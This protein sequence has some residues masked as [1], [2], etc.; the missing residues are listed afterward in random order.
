[1]SIGNAVKIDRAWKLAL[2]RA[3]T[4]VAKEFFEEEHP[5][6]RI[7]HA[8]DVWKDSIPAD[9]GEAVS[10][11]VAQQH[12]HLSLEEDVT[13]SGKRAWI[14]R[15]DG[16]RLA[17]WISPRFGQ[18][19]TIQL[20]DQAGNQIFTTDPCNWVFD[21]KSGILFLENSH[22]TA[23]GFKITGYRYIG[24]KGVGGGAAA[25]NLQEVYDAGA[26]DAV[27]KLDAGGTISVKAADDT[28]LLTVEEGGRRVVLK[29]PLIT[30]M[31]VKVET[32]DTEVKDN[33]LTLNKQ[34]SG[35]TPPADFNSGIEVDRGSDVSKP[36]LR[37][38]NLT[39]KWQ[40]SFDE[41]AFFDL[42]VEGQQPAGTTRKHVEQVITPTKTVVIANMMDK[43]NLPG[44][45]VQIF[46][47]GTGGVLEQVEAEVK[48]SSG[49]GTL[50]IN[51][52]E[53]FAGYI[54]VTG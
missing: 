40:A 19:F 36:T 35:Q 21:Y 43:V 3:L 50:T 18:G 39:K 20:F 37:W 28:P 27:V 11:G 4:S 2:D 49:W 22:A 30:G 44:A 38:N 46:E 47:E 23:T 5:S 26:K 45:A 33:L 32:V 1:M 24:E 10:A 25:Q 6:G 54:V 31:A 42:M 16:N 7:V 34:A 14:A 53:N 12:L 17:D 8:G 41:D 52:E 13:V 29:D 15:S 48:W 9:P 51:F